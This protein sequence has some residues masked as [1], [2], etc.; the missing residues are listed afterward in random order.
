MLTVTNY[1]RLPHAQDRSTIIT[2]D[3]SR[4]NKETL[5]MIKKKEKR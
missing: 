3:I 2:Y 5:S 1:E 4:V